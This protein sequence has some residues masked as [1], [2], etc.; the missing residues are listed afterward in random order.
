MREQ[1]EYLGIAD[2]AKFFGVPIVKIYAAVK[3]GML[4]PDAFFRNRT[5]RTALW[6]LDR[7][8]RLRRLMSG[9][10]EHSKTGL[11]IISAAHTSSA[12]GVSRNMW[13]VLPRTK[14]NE[15][16]ESNSQ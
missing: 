15:N 4:P 3:D 10:G 8:I 14:T 16:F 6:N 11:W 5:H 2:V 12:V 7:L 9:K 13:R 1:I